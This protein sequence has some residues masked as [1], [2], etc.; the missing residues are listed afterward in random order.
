[1]TVAGEAPA[2]GDLF[3]WLSDHTVRVLTMIGSWVA[4]PVT[5]LGTLW[6]A[7]RSE[8]PRLHVEIRSCA[9][10]VTIDGFGHREI[11][12]SVTNVGQRPTTIE[13]IGFIA[14]LGWRRVSYKTGPRHLL[15]TGNN[16]EDRISWHDLTNLSDFAS[17]RC[18]RAAVYT[19]TASKT[20]RIGRELRKLLREWG[21][22]VETVWVARPEQQMDEAPS[23]DLLSQRSSDKGIDST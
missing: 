15:E 8:K 11:S 18:V 10:R 21:E 22:N 20:V 2:L 7:R 4:P 14:R 12:F 17:W 19:P 6:L 13:G 3:P 1:M 23:P 5:I 16:L 9:P